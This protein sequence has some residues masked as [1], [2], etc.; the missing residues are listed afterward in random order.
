MPPE[1]RKFQPH[2]TLGRFREPPPQQRLAS[3]IAGRALFRGEPFMV[4]GFSLYSSVLRPEGALHVREAVYD[5]V[6]GVM[7]RV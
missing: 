3:F 5:F 1:R 2:V 6:S 7:E 4:S